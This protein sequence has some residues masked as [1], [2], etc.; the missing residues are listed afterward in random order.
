MTRSVLVSVALI[1]VGKPTTTIWVHAYLLKMTLLGVGLYWDFII[2]Y[3]DPKVLP[4]ALLFMDCCQIIVAVGG[5]V[6][7]SSYS[8]VLL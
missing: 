6:L 5:Y 2:S 8:T 4:K 1:T 3:L 7:R